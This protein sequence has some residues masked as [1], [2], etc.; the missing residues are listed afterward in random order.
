MNYLVLLNSL[1]GDSISIGLIGGDVSVTKLT[2][3]QQL[4]DRVP[5][6][7]VLG[8]PEIRALAA[9][10]HPA[11]L[12]LLRARVRLAPDLLLVL[13]IGLIR[14]G[15]FG[16]RRGRLWPPDLIA[17]VIGGGGGVAA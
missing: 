4:P 16:A 8:V 12:L 14:S 10:D 5:L 9:R 3:P 6:V 1:D 2:V 7:K 13:L 15:G 11:L 17:V